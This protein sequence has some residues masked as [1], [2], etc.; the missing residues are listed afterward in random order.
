[1]LNAQIIGMIFF[2]LLVFVF[3]SELSG[4]T[5]FPGGELYYILGLAVA[6][7]SWLVWMARKNNQKGLTESIEAD[8]RPPVLFLR[9]FDKDGEAPVSIFDAVSKNSKKLITYEDV[10][11]G[12]TGMVGPVIAIASP[13]RKEKEILGAAKAHFGD[14]QTAIHGFMK[15][16]SLIIMRPY[17]SEGVLWE[18]EQVIKLG[19]LGKTILFLEFGGKD[20]K[21]AKLAYKDNE[22]AYENF[23]Q[24]LIR[25]YTIDV[26][27]YNPKAQRTFF[28]SRHEAYETNDYFDIP[29]FRKVF[30]N[31][32]IIAKNKG[33]STV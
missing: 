33:K 7:I 28:D 29:V 23:R 6:L 21:Q 4:I 15:A 8:R 12:Y 20:T 32:Y 24:A 26:G 3:H 22:L 25:D 16:A 18:F 1:M 13:Y 31:G 9:S 11:I 5:D 2:V 14:W 27:A 30:Y 10:A 19:Y 17:D